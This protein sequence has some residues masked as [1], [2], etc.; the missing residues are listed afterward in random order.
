MNDFLSLMLTPSIMIAVCASLLIS[1][2]NRNTRVIERIRQIN[3]IILGDLYKLP[4]AMLENY[5]KQIQLFRKRSFLI[6]KALFLN[7][8]AL[9]FFILTSLSAVAIKWHLKY[10]PVTFFVL[11]M[12]FLLAFTILLIRESM[13]NFET[14]ELDIEN[15]ENIIGKKDKKY[16][17]DD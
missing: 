4:N 9:L 17:K 12:F 8:L 11:G 14:T 15:V 3:R 6:R 5:K 7:Y 10:L 16:K 1:T 13:I 2:T